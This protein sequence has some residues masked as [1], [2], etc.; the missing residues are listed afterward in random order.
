MKIKIGNFEF[1]WTRSHTFVAVVAGVLLLA[2]IFANTSP[3]TVADSGPAST[4]PAPPGTTPT[5]PESPPAPGTPPQAPGTPPVP[6]GNVPPMAPFPIGNSV[7]L[8]EQQH[9]QVDFLAR[10][11]ML[12]VYMHE[13]G[14]MMIRELNL[15]ATGPEEDVAD[16][17][18]AFSIAA[19]MTGAPEN[20]KD[21]YANVLYAGALFWKFEAQDQDP[22]HIQWSDEHS[23]SL[24]RYFNILCIAYGA[25]PARFKAISQREGVTEVRMQRCLGDYKRQRAAWDALLAPYERN[26]PSSDGPRLTLRIDDPGK[27]EW[28]AFSQFYTYR[29]FFQQFLNVI[30]DH[31]K[32]PENVSVIVKGCNVL[33]AW[34]SDDA[35]TVTMCND[36]FA[37]LEDT[38][39]TAVAQQAGGG[40]TPPQGPPPGP[41]QGPPQGPPMGGNLDQA[42]IGQWTCQMQTQTGPATENDVFLADGEFS[43]N[44]IWQN[45]AT[46]SAWGKWS[47]P[48]PGTL[49][50]D[51]AG[52]TQ[53]GVAGS[54][55]N[56]P[57]QMPSPN[58]LQISNSL[59]QKMG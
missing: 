25:D 52:S 29:G 31:T 48:M 57:F 39:A 7:Q 41:P 18:A 33:N 38:F 50:Y 13:T 40:G 20:Q 37:Y 2:V 27:P 32:L 58:V 1:D 4:V 12:F 10:G 15:P 6:G 44:S 43:T 51:I 16:E 3:T 21:F 9:Q 28:A 23:P 54:Q 46:M 42:L 35:K 14:H 34:W 47:V 26:P 24:K 19:I 49:R 45:G 55:V 56:I 36:L 11:A 22:S 30:A 17:F 59:C 8:T 53:P 5:P